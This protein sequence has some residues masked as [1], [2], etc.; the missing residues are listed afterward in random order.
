MKVS[1]VIRIHNRFLKNRFD[2]C[3]REV[4]AASASPSAIPCGAGSGRPTATATPPSGV[5]EEKASTSQRQQQQ[6]GSSGGCSPPRLHRSQPGPESGSAGSSLNDEN[7]RQ[8]ESDGSDSRLTHGGEG[9]NHLGSSLSVNA[10][11]WRNTQ[12]SVTPP[13]IGNSSSSRPDPMSESP[14]RRDA[15]ERAAVVDNSGTTSTNAGS[16]SNSKSSATEG[17]RRKGDKRSSSPSPR[18]LEYLFFTGRRGGTGGIEGGTGGREPSGGGRFWGNT[19]WGTASVGD[20]NA[21]ESWQ[22]DLLKLAEDGFRFPDWSETETEA[23]AEGA[24]GLAEP[25]VTEAGGAA[26]TSPHLTSVGGDTTAA[27]AANKYPHRGGGGKE[28]KPPRPQSIVLSTHLSKTDIPRMNGDIVNAAAAQ[29]S[30]VDS[31][32]VAPPASIGLGGGE[33]VPPVC[34]VLVVKVYTGRTCRVPCGSPSG[35]GSGVGAGWGRGRSDSNV[36]R[37]PR[38]SVL[39]RAWATGFKAVCVSDDDDKGE[40]GERRGGNGDGGSYGGSCIKNA[41]SRYQ[42]RFAAAFSIRTPSSVGYATCG[43]F[44]SISS[45]FHGKWGR[46]GLHLKRHNA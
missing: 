22:P 23:D 33:F 14:G 26:H 34:R 42:V 19:T 29:A 27:A 11:A 46:V 12:G 18:S 15:A 30:K 1:R 25:S 16:K 45:K 41:S 10:A 43:A 5:F 6:D 40:G 7:K 9:G 13:D 2:R 17:E 8:L 20:G 44:C 24:V 3:V 35:D 28:C 21:Y 32:G 31:S 37:V 38:P 36:G 39:R 4:N